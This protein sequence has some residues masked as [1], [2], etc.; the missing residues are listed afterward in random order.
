MALPHRSSLPGQVGFTLLELLVA[1][2]V[3]AIMSIAAYSGLSSVLFTHTAVEA[4]AR[5]LARVQMAFHILEQDLQQIVPRGI[6]DEYGQ[7]QPALQSGGLGGYILQLT[8][9]GWAN[10]LGRPRSTLQRLAYRVEE[11][12]LLRLYWETLDRGNAAEP[13]QTVLLDGVR[14]MTARFLDSEQAWQT[15]WPSSPAAGKSGNSLP[16]A[17]EVRLILD[18]WGVL[19]RLFLLPE[20]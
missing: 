9:S 19:T 15:Q 2:A 10:P 13:R 12:R 5:R 18:D 4:E 11:E 1:L 16:R 8:R 20:S 14:E 17:V 6:R 7:P 3:F